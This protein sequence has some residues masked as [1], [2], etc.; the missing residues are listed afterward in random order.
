MDRKETESS[1]DPSEQSSEYEDD[2]NDFAILP[3]EV[4]KELNSY[5][6]EQYF[7]TACVKPE[8]QPN[9]IHYNPR[10]WLE[11]AWQTA[12]LDQQGK[13]IQKHFS[14]PMSLSKSSDIVGDLW[15]QMRIYNRENMEKFLGLSFLTESQDF[16][17]AITRIR[18]MMEPH[19]LSRLLGQS[20]RTPEYCA[21]VLNAFLTL[22]NSSDIRHQLGDGQD[23][24][25]LSD[26]DRDVEVFE[27]GSFI[28]VAESG[29]EE[30]ANHCCEQIST[31][32]QHETCV[33]KSGPNLISDSPKDDPLFDKD[34]SEAEEGLTFNNVD[35]ESFHETVSYVVRK[36]MKKVSGLEFYKVDDF[37]CHCV[38][39]GIK[40]DE[41]SVIA[42]HS[43][44]R[45]KQWKWE[46]GAS[47]LAPEIGPTA[48]TSRSTTQL[49]EKATEHMS[50]QDLSR[51]ALVRVDSLMKA[52]S[53]AAVK[54]VNVTR[55]EEVLELI[56]PVGCVAPSAL[57]FIANEAAQFVLRTTS[58][59][60]RRAEKQTNNSV[61]LVPEDV[62][63]AAFIVL[64]KMGK[65]SLFSEVYGDTWEQVK[66]W[67]SL[68]LKPLTK[69]RR[70]TLCNR[71]PTMIIDVPE[72]ACEEV[73]M[74][75]M[76]QVAS[77]RKC[78]LSDQIASVVQ[79]EADDSSRDAPGVEGDEEQK[80]EVDNT[81]ERQDHNEDQDL[82]TMSHIVHEV[83][84]DPQPDANSVNDEIKAFKKMKLSVRSHRKISQKQKRER[85]NSL[86]Q[87]RE[88]DHYEGDLEDL[89]NVLKDKPHSNLT[90]CVCI[91]RLAWLILHALG[92]K[93]TSRGEQP[94]EHPLSYGDEVDYTTFGQLRCID[95]QIQTQT[96]IKFGVGALAVLC[97]F[98]DTFIRDE[99]EILMWCASHDDGR[100]WIDGADVALVQALRK[101]D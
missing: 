100:P 54:R 12:Q 97:T 19:C 71:K 48:V 88:Y 69:T 16:F 64:S 98:V 20:F 57:L 45:V 14:S 52:L 55:S 90:Q 36:Y 74:T 80:K 79:P 44:F 32:K 89:L 62:E 85:G 24:C 28:C 18:G 15:S 6:S 68:F 95:G 41:P 94:S 66:N 10:I 1:P 2:Y 91:H 50:S 9:G 86:L 46:H 56:T 81:C 43:I 84:S 29:D 75:V 77:L 70:F 13:E 63:E 34:G 59:A 23:Q 49:W 5:Q 60:I 8:L 40:F 73:K 76:S 25:Q 67:E 82:D 65:V 30:D 3:E 42:D 51:C 26:P 31:E 27:N 35:D 21:F 39:L 83:N 53:Y 101:T 38:E 99:G 17:H 7:N 96:R 92:E 87:L 47:M 11:G 78:A 93:D 22:I 33:L 61:T 37:R 58:V 72:D 4:R